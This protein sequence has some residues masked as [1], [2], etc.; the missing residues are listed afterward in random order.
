MSSPAKS[1][2]VRDLVKTYKG[3][4]VVNEVTLGVEPGQIVGLLGPE[5]GREI[6]HLLQCGGDHS[7][8]SRC[9]HLER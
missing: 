7:P 5:R 1:L 9:G 2:M 4:C 8:R 3:R 6:H